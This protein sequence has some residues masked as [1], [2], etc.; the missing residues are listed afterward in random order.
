MSAFHHRHRRWCDAVGLVATFAICATVP[1]TATAQEHEHEHDHGDHEGQLHFAHPIF[2]ESP[3][4]DTMK[5]HVGRVHHLV[6]GLGGRVPITHERDSEHE[7][8]LS[9]LWHF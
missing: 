5:Y 3:S 2:T 4:P 7:V 9:A 8:L 6:L 1:F